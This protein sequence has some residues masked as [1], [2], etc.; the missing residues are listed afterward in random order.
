MSNQISVASTITQAEG[1]LLE[2]KNDRMLQD[3]FFPTPETAIFPTSEVLFDMDNGDWQVAPTVSTGYKT[4]NVVSFT[5]NAVQPPRVAPE[6]V[7]DP[8]DRD[9]VMFESLCYAANG[10]RALAYEAYRRIVARKLGDTVY[11]KIEMFIVDMLM[12]MAIEGTMPTSP[13]DDTPVPIQIKFYDDSEGNQQR[14]LPAYAWG[15]ASATPCRDVDAMVNAL[16]EHSG[17]PSILLISP[18]AYAL[19]SRDPEFK[20]TFEAYHGEDS[21]LCGRP[22]KGARKVAQRVFGGYPLDIVVYS[23]S[24][25]DENKIRHHYLPKG[26]VCVL[27]ANVGETKCGGAVLMNPSAIGAEEGSS[28]NAFVQRRG[29]VIGSEFIDLRNQRLSVRMESRPLPAPYR[30]WSWITMDAMNNNEISGGSVGAVVS[31]DFDSDDDNATLP[32]DLTNQLGG[33][34]VTIADATTTTVG[35]S[36]DGYYVNGAKQTKDGDGKYTLPMINSIWEARFA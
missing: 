10:D 22:Y 5:S 28:I 19:L 23:G 29:K 20:D 35:V 15:N 33:S 7:I 24:W 2:S 6:T 8:M 30:K 13:T 18:E 16:A 31:V 26:F 32:S 36:F 21:Y 25:Q 27:S 11:R 17:E 14:Y 3:V 4:T 1:Y 12:N 34:K 9:R